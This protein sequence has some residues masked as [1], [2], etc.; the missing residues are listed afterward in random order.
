[1]AKKTKGHPSII[2]HGSDGH[3]GLLGI[4]QCDEPKRKAELEQALTIP[5]VV[6]KKKPISRQ[7]YAPQTRGQSGDNIF[8]GW[9]RQGR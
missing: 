2:A 1:M 9:K 7:N 6:S 3:R 4:D 5:P 8:N